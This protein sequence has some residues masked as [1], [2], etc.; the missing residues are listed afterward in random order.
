MCVQ[1]L[2]DEAQRCRR[3]AKSIYN[4]MATAE[5][6]AHARALEEQAAKLE[7]AKS[8]SRPPEGAA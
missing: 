5:L 8:L 1:A 2:R 3:L 6:E 4:Q 7:A